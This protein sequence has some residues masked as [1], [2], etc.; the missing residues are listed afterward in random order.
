MFAVIPL[1]VAAIVI[2]AIFGEVVA[3]FYSEPFNSAIRTRWR[4]QLDHVPGKN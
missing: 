2:S 3:R 1:F 4:G